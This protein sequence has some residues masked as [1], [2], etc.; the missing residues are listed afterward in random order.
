V[1]NKI[2]SG[3]N[4]VDD[5]QGL[6]EAPLKLLHNIIEEGKSLKVL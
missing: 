2:E 1:E 6:W 3:K 5:L 4:A